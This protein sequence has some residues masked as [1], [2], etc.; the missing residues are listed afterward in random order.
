MTRHV[1]SDLAAYV[2]GLLSPRRTL[3]VRDHVF[4][5]PT[6]CEKL[7]R[8]E[9]LTADLRLSL[10][11]NP[12]PRDRQAAE[13]WQQIVAAPADQPPR[14][15]IVSASIPVLLSLALLIFPATVGFGA[16]HVHAAPP[17]ATAR[18]P[19]ADVTNLPPLGALQTEEPFDSD[20]PLPSLTAS[21]TPLA[22]SILTPAPAPFAP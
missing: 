14:R 12:C 5:C 16:A 4:H 20:A 13:W 22:E 10:G 11:Q 8:H 2:E 21:A 3:R 7:A 18:S 6:C 9:R 17:P 1:D 15:W 19:V